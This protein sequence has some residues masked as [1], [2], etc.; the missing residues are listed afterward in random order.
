MPRIV[1]VEGEGKGTVF[2]VTGEATIGRSSHNPV[3]LEGTQISRVHAQVIVRDGIFLINDCASKNGLRINGQRYNEKPLERGDRIEIG[4]VTLAWDPDFD[5]MTREGSDGGVILLGDE[6]QGDSTTCVLTTPIETESAAT[7][8]S[9]GLAG[10][11]AGPGS[12]AAGAAAA[13]LTPAQAL[14]SAHRRLK[15]VYDVISVTSAVLD[16]RQLIDRLLEVVQGIFGAERGAVLFCKEDGSEIYPGG[17]RVREAGSRDVP[18]SRSVLK[19]VLRERR[20][21]ISS[22]AASD[23]RFDGSKSLALDQVKSVLCAPLIHKD[24]LQ[25]AIYLDT[26]SVLKNFGEE[27]L[28]LLMNIS[29][30]A[31]V[32]IDN[33]RA[34]TRTREEVSQLRRRLLDD[35]AIIGE[36]PQIREVLHRIEKVA[37]TN[38]TVLITGETGTGKELVAHAIHHE[39]SR[40]NKAF[41]AVDCTAISETLLESELFG[42]EKGAFTGADRLKPGRFELANGGTIFLDEI[43]DMNMATQ[44]K[45]LRVLEERAFTRVGGVRL[46]NVDVRIVAATNQHLELRIKEGRFREDL[47]YRLAVV[48]I[49]LPP[50]RE[51]RSDVPILAQHYLKK[52]A[53]ENGRTQPELAGEVLAALAGYAWPGNIRELRNVMERALVLSETGTIGVDDLPLNLRSGGGGGGAAGASGGAGAVSASGAATA[54]VP[55]EEDLAMAEAVQ[56]LERRM[57]QRALDRARG[58][59]IE[60]ARLLQISRPTLD[61]KLKEYGLELP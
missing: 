27:D 28:S 31:A 42:H 57:I 20:G 40:R 33:V 21:L 10:A 22:D 48:P 3:H 49:Q 30:Q 9:V 54:A 38:S 24:R 7:E 43:G 32:A 1:V 15:A 50:L 17:I 14:E 16:E 39:S 6:E 29:R 56:R 11:G 61:K 55:G 8:G 26:R 45:L 23:P 34:Y 41:V 4:T 18:I 59:K 35:H 19:Y 47:Y 53:Q 12:G 58:K 36:S 5:V 44:I 60:A 46:M 2:E 37:G 13:T 25:G 51:R 52:F